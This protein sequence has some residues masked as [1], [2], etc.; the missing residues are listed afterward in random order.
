MILSRMWTRRYTY[1][2]IAAVGVTAA[3]SIPLATGAEGQPPVGG[4]SNK[5]AGVVS[6]R[7][8]QAKQLS[9]WDI[10]GTVRG[11]NSR[12]RMHFYLGT[13]AGRKCYLES[14]DDAAVPEFSFSAC[15]PSDSKLLTAEQPLL[16]FSAYLK[17][18]ATG[19]I[20]ARWLSG[21]AADGVA[22]VGILG[23]DGSV[24]AKTDVVS[25]VYALRDVPD[26][27]ISALV[28]Y[29]SRGVIVFSQEMH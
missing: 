24:V 5:G 6:L 7:G 28:A 13:S 10:D 19:P 1:A 27:P 26:E 22:A 29:D 20:R 2:L 14:N 21:I 8:T 9:A 17:S 25:N 16:D 3:V 23:L 12:G 15:V 4:L 11:L 18:P